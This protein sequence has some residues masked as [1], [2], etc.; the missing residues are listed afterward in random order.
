MWGSLIV[1]YFI[2]LLGRSRGLYSV[3]LIYLF[4][5]TFYLPVDTY[6]SIQPK[7]LITY[8]FNKRCDTYIYGIIHKQMQCNIFIYSYS[9]HTCIQNKNINQWHR[10]KIVKM[11][12]HLGKPQSLSHPLSPQRRERDP[13][14]LPELPISDS[15]FVWWFL[16]I[17]TS[18]NFPC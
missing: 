1:Q 2:I 7:I 14:L 5:V 3:F 17:Y 4:K 8:S 9:Q 12:T 13:T 16:N 6:C 15:T 11:E 18:K 10:V